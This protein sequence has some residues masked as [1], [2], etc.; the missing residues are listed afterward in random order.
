MS[1]IRDQALAALAGVL[2][3]FVAAYFLFEAVATRQPPRRAFHG[4]GEAVTAGQPGGGAEPGNPGN[5]GA[6]PVPDAAP[7]APFMERVNEI[8]REIAASPGDP[9]PRQTLA[10]LYF[11]AG[12]WP[13]AEAAYQ[14]YLELAPDDPDALSDLGVCLYQQG[15]FDEALALFRRVQEVVPGHWQSRF[16]EAVVLAFGLKRYEEAEALVEELRRDQPDN[17][18]VERLAAGIEE[19]KAA[20]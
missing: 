9:A 4:D 8:E 19:S 13:Q 10:N 15:R 3:G 14:R 7:R 2:V 20:A 11:D 1:A 12:L 5:P 6:G 16:N 18:T 17:P